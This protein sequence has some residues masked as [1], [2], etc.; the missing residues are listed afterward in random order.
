MTEMKIAMVKL[1]QKFKVEF[2]ETTRIDL[3]N[4]DMFLFNFSQLNIRFVKRY[5]D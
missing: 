1:L 2:D 3:V 4:G 5:S